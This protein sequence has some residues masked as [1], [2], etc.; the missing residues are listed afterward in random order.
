MAKFNAR[1]SQNYKQQS[2]VHR[3]TLASLVSTIATILFATSTFVQADVKIV[4]NDY[5]I[6]AVDPGIKI[7]VR[8]K[9]QEG[10]KTFADDNIVVFLHGATFPSGGTRFVPND[11]NRVRR[12]AL[13]R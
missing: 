6:D 13:G 1:L 2:S 4:K 3:R 12:S 9:M 7:F 5:L 11:S 8:E 10:N